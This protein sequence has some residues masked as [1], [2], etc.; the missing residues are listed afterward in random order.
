MQRAGSTSYVRVSLHLSVSHKLPLVLKWL[1]GR[2]W[3]L[4]Q[5]LPVIYP[6][7]CGAT[8]PCAVSGLF[9]AHKL[10]D[11]LLNTRIL[12]Q[13]FITRDFTSVQFMCCEPVKKPETGHRSVMLVLVTLDLH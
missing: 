1:N 3:F 12:M 10:N 2:S 7:H 13:L 6:I 11:S 9:T 8:D 5:M 4:A